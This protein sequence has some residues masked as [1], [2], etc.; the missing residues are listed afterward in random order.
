VAKQRG[1][2]LQEERAEVG[3]AG[4]KGAIVSEGACGGATGTE[5]ELE[6][7]CDSHVPYMN[8]IPEEER[9]AACTGM[10]SRRGEGSILVALLRGG[11]ELRGSKSGEL[12]EQLLGQPAVA[13]EKLEAP[14]ACENVEPKVQGRSLKHTSKR[15][16]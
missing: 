9:A 16:A 5:G 14:A 2:S 4:V 8:S 11:G 7:A 6:V 12:H 10:G 15:S 3:G 13:A 1:D